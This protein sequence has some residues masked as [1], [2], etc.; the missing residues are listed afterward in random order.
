[1][2]WDDALRSVTAAPAAAFGLSDYGTLE[3]GKVANVVV[4]SGDPFDFMSAPEHV[5]IRG[6]EVSLKTRE[7]ELRD[8]YRTLPPR[9][10]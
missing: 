2:G 5:L 10:P 3:N 1:M 6:Q 4:W 7:T 9:V 8:K